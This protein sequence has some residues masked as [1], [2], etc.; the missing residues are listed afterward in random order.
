M[1]VFLAHLYCVQCCFTHSFEDFLSVIVEHHEQVDLPA[2]VAVHRVH[3]QRAQTC[4]R[5]GV[6]SAVEA[7][8]ICII[9][10]KHDQIKTFVFLYVYFNVLCFESLSRLILVLFLASYNHIYSLFR[11]VF[12]LLKYLFCHVALYLFSYMKFYL[13]VLHYRFTVII[14]TNCNY[15]ISRFQDKTDLIILFLCSHL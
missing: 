10:Y 4:S 2:G 7:V 15:G 11:F 13:F 9:S 14:F 5:Q 8:C 6:G 12:T 1:S 3:L